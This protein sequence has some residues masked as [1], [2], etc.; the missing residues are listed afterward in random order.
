MP[1]VRFGAPISGGPCRPRHDRRCTARRRGRGRARRLRRRRPARTATARSRLRRRS[2]LLSSIWSMPNRGIAMS[3]VSAWLG[4]DA[5]TDRLL[6][7]VDRSAPQP[8]VVVEVRIALE[9]LRA[10]AVAGRAIVGELRR[11][12]AQD[13][14]HQ[15][16][17]LLDLGDRRRWQSP[18]GD[19]P[20]RPWTP[21]APRS[22]RRA[23][24]S[25]D[26][27]SC[28][29]RASAT[30]GRTSSS[31]RPTRWMRRAC[32]ATSAAAACSAP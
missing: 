24:C 27:P 11:A 14:L 31:R 6:D 22:P 19:A 17:I 28:S 23:G 10:A 1:S 16:G 32:R 30:P 13:E 9:A 4:A 20:A 26:S 21:R 18:R 2:A 29:R 5:V 25:R 12:A 8:I 7:G 3:C 15:V